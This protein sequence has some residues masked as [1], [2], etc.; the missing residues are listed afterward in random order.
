MKTTKSKKSMTVNAENINLYRQG[1]PQGVSLTQL[2]A[3]QTNVFSGN[4]PIY[5][6]EENS[7]IDDFALMLQEVD[8]QGNILS[9]QNTPAP[10]STPINLNLKSLFGI[11]HSSSKSKFYKLTINAIDTTTQQVVAT[12]IRDF[13]VKSTARSMSKS[14]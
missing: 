2:A 14:R 13:E 11:T 10:I 6:L 3:F 7:N 4:D 5:L 1:N 12:I 9:T 8:I